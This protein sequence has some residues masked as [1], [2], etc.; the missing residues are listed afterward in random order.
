MTAF[1]NEHDP[2][3]AQYLRN[4]ISAN[5][6]APGVV[7]ERD[8][9]EIEAYELTGFTQVHL[10]AGIGI[11]SGALRAAGWPDWEPIWTGSF[12]CQPF[13]QAGQRKGINDERHLWP[14][15]LDLIAQCRPPRFAGEQVASKDGR[16]WLDTVST[17]LEALEFAFGASDL[18]AAGFQQAHIRQR[19]YFAG[20]ADFMQPGRSEGRARTGD[21]PPSCGGGG[22]I[23]L[24]DD[25]D[26]RLERRTGMSECGNKFAIREG[27]LDGRLG[28]SDAKPTGRDVGTVCQSFDRK[29]RE[30]NF[31]NARAS[32]PLS[33]LEYSDVS[34]KHKRTSSREQSLHH[35]DDATVQRN[36]VLHQGKIASRWYDVDWLL[37]RN[38]SG[39]PSWRPVEPG[40]FPLA[41]G[42]PSRMGKLRSYGNALDFQTAKAFCEVL[43]DICQVGL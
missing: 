10:C 6:I 26:S 2:Y 33:G 23:G 11:W 34:G 24:A 8:L 18:C 29:D 9:Q 1:Y 17:D 27:G 21:G 20:L 37:T 35:D 19:N 16:Q 39:N 43:V 15:G 3:A 40:T 12:P 38:P 32:S 36:A 41:H 7:D 22:A 30:P 25:D 5:L 14:V 42:V 4:L 13:S 31:S 28:H